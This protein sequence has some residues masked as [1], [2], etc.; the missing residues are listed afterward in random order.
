[1]TQYFYI[2]VI[3]MLI[4]S[5]NSV[6]LALSWCKMFL[7]LGRSSWTFWRNWGKQTEDYHYELTV[8]LSSSSAVKTYPLISKKVGTFLL[9]RLFLR[10][11]FVRADL[12]SKIQ[13]NDCCFFVRNHSSIGTHVLAPVMMLHTKL[14]HPRWKRSSRYRSAQ[15]HTIFCFS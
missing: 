5:D 4:Y 12:F 10:T 6:I 14:D 15:S 3:K 13:N 1:M 2:L 8:R 11:T 7:P 9:F